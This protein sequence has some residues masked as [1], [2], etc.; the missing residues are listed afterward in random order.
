[1]RHGVRT[2]LHR[3]PLLL[4]CAGLLFAPQL[5]AADV[6]AKQA[7][8]QRLRARIA[9]LQN[10]LDKDKG[11]YGNLLRELRTVE[12]RIGQLGR[13]IETLRVQLTEQEKKLAALQ[14]RRGEL[15]RSVSRQQGYLAGQIRASYA[16]GRQEYL[17]IL[18]NQEEPAAV[19]RTLTYYDY[20]NKARTERI[21]K[22]D[23]TLNEL[24]QVRAELN[25][26]TEQ[27]RALHR[28]R[29]EE[30]QAMESS[31]R[32]RKNVVKRLKDEIGSKDK[33]MESL[34][35]NERELN[36]LLQ[37]LVNAL[38]DIPAEAGNHKPFAS[39]RGRLKWPTHGRRLIAYGEPREQGNMR[40]QGVVIAGRE[41]QEV[42]AVSHGRVAFS[43]WLRG[44]GLLLIIDHGD[45]YM[46]L[47]GHNQSLYRE[48][49]D[50]VERGD[51]IATVGNS[52]GIERTALYF[53]IRKD[54]KPTDP[55][56][57]CRG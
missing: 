35:A 20:L 29:S 11:R 53:E 7:E 45:G 2:I 32:D 1:M 46:S 33:Q 44:F 49:G 15:Q 16:M 8:L 14:R 31:R 12:R 23:R 27:L 21:D 41:G 9:T 34:Q 5:P 4:L 38:E 10:E 56:R 3:L 19:G 36:S 42:R 28:K 25:R 54:G 18:L 37:S 50:W 6:Q 47:Y 43:D 30:K 13:N 22:L 55:I 48:A 24:E 51:L 39:L 40:W 26:E 52:G 57:W 17:K